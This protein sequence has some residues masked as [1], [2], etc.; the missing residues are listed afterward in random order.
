VSYTFAIGD[1]HGCIDPLKR[2]LANI[3]AYASGG[4]VVFL[5]DY[6][7]RGPDSRS[8]VERLI[9]G[10]PSSS[11]KWIALKGNHEDMMVGVHAGQCDQSWWLANG[12]LKTIQSYENDIPEWHL[13]WAHSLP[14]MH[15]DEHRI[16]VHAGVREGA[17]L[18]D[19]TPKD[20][21]WTRVP[22]DYSSTYW[23]KH[24]CHGHTASHQNPLTVGNRTN[25]DSACVFGGKLS[26]A[27][28]DDS[29][30]GGPIA[31]LDVKA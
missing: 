18:E 10:P 24:L 4:T 3:A 12:G 23:G 29:V 21:L 25:V 5:G 20:L 8:V 16:F 14:L 7:D 27:V 28:F 2:L 15:M 13:E 30:P 22:D 31:F 19:Q 26:C 1:I 11:W 9:S 17:Y 6:V